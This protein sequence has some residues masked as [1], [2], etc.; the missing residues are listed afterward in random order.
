MAYYSIEELNELGFKK[1]GSNVLISKKA[2]LYGCSE[3]EIGD[4]VR[5]DDFCILSGNIRIGSNVHI[6]AYV[7]LY[8][9]MGIILD[10]FTGIS[11][12]TTIFSA[13]DDFSGEYLIGPIHSGNQIKVTGGL[14]RL[15]RFSQ[16]GAHCVVFPNLTIEEGAVVGAMSL[17]NKTIP[18]WTIYVGTP[19]KYL[20][21]RSTKLL[22]LI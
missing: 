1:I 13:M 10:D 5:I 18:Q 3:M 14:V 16:I 4:N 11:P 12:R 15:K 9:K 17:V 20:K 21:P 2:S 19:A 8:G 22:D 7:A 6:S